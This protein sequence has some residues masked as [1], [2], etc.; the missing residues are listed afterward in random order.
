KIF[1]QE[2]RFKDD[3]GNDFADWEEKKLGDVITNKTEKY[4]P[5]KEK[6]NYKCIEL[7]HLVSET[8]TLLGYVDSSNSGSI[9][10]KFQKG[11][12]LFG[13]L[14]PYLKKYL[15]A[16]FDGVCSSEIWV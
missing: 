12:V 5:E 1:D 6:V 9:K 10:N 2:I 16:P 14:R 15:Q 7:E 4:N 3:N 11:D 13:K 8:P